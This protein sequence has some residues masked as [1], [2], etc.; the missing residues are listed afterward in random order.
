MLCL[1]CALPREGGSWVRKEGSNSSRGLNCLTFFGYRFS[2]PESL[3]TKNSLSF[4]LVTCRQEDVSSLANHQVPFAKKCAGRGDVKMPAQ[5]C[6]AGNNS[7]F[8]YC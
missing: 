7:S 8:L 6:L 2:N 4:G 5:A 1:G 3:E